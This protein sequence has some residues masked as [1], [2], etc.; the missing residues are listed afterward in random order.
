MQSFTSLIKESLVS[1]D[2]IEALKKNC[3]L[4]TTLLCFLSFK[5]YHL[6]DNHQVEIKLEENYLARLIYYV[7]K[8]LAVNFS[9]EKYINSSGKTIYK[10]L[11]DSN[12][13]TK[14][15]EKLTGLPRQKCCRHHW[16]R[17]AF[18]CSG[19]I[20][21]PT[22]NY[23]L[24]F[25]TSSQSN[26]ENIQKVLT[27]EEV[28]AKYYQKSND[29][30]HYV[31]Y[32]KKSEHIIHFLALTGAHKQLLDIENMLIEKNI[33]NTIIRQVNYETANLEKTIESS[34]R[35]I[36]AIEWA[37]ENGLFNDLPESLKEVALVRVKYP[38]KNLRELCELFPKPITKS[39][40]N[41]R[42]RRLYGIIQKEK[43]KISE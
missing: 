20:S 6:A 35:Y 17:T 32:I 29:P 40:I 19:Y 33:K 28:E 25:Y 13:I 5:N 38:D 26:V 22:R 9:R 41:H 31:L 1:S 3:C 18:L 30:E 12:I 10:F 16:L 39:G 24:E 34:V 27:E 4:K 43:S 21:D 7:L 11:A 37:I 15:L 14:N 8:K 2:K 42:L 23:H 36:H